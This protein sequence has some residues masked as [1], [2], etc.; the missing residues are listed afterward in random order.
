MSSL[1]SWAATLSV[2]LS[3]GLKEK[4]INLLSEFLRV[5]HMPCSNSQKF[6]YNLFILSI[7]FSIFIETPNTIVIKK[8]LTVIQRSRKLVQSACNSL[9]IPSVWRERT[10][11]SRYSRGPILMRIFRGTRKGKC[12]RIFFLKQL[13]HRSVSRKKKK[14]KSDRIRKVANWL[15]HL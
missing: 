6:F 8:S 1:M 3:L 5:T 9:S 10:I 12:H 4:K 11:G 13:F 15:A 2:G 14:E 7:R